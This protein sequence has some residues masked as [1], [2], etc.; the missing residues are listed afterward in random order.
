MAL[1]QIYRRNLRLTAMVDAVRG[2]RMLLLVP[3][4]VNECAAVFR[5]H[6]PDITS[7]ESIFVG[8]ESGD[9]Y[10]LFIGP[11][12]HEDLV[13]EPQSRNEFDCLLAESLHKWDMEF[14]AVQPG[15][16]TSDIAKKMH[17]E[18][19][20]K[21]KKGLPLSRVD[22]LILRLAIENQNI[23][24]ITDDAMLTK[25][26]LSKCGQG[27]ASHALR[28]YFGRLN[29]T[30]DFLSRLLK[31]GF[32]GCDP[33]R[34]RI[35]YHARDMR[36][37]KTKGS[38]PSTPGPLDTSGQDS[39]ML[40]AVGASPDNMRTE[41]GM[42]IRNLKRGDIDG[43]LYALTTFVRLVVLDWYCVCGDANG[44]KFDKE[45]H[46]AEYGFD[47]MQTVSKTR[48][49][50]YDT[51][52]SVLEKNRKRYCACDRPDERQLHEAF[53][54]IASKDDDTL[55]KHIFDVWKKRLQGSAR[56]S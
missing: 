18:K 44:A 7:A 50:Y 17:A 22:C 30:A 45:W 39:S 40:F 25:A 2:D 52:K 24:V 20:Y 11:V 42:A 48:K 38:R 35:E 3:D 14:A 47:I 12:T 55:S 23:D 21:N 16:G 28:N 41:R 56:E 26:M 8:D 10:E 34:D 54:T 33:I 29:M 36:V 53:K 13:V 37:D 5:T 27:R 31:V 51:A 1:L 6:K 4:V 19:P 43:V 9:V 32:I 49:S 15:S 46:D